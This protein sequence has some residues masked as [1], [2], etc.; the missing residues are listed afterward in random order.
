MTVLL[1]HIAAQIALIPVVDRVPPA[2]L[3]YGTDLSCVLDLTTDLREVD[4]MTA[5]A[6]GEAI[7]RR[8]ITPR[9]AL[10]DDGAYGTDVR[11]KLNTPMAQQDVTRL[12][13]QVRGEALKDD[14]VAE[15]TATVIIPAARQLRI[16]LAVTPQLNTL[17]F[18]LTFF[19][20]A[21]GI[22]L[23]ESIDSHG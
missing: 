16:S 2:A 22:Q 6:I 10:L 21:D 5:R 14:R 9:G 15:A 23:Q 20:T 12:E 11:G 4:A 19:V 3:G 17:P 1:D 8:L 13:I 7:V 18:T